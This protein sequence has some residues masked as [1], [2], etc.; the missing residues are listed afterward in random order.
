MDFQ[1]KQGLPF[2]I[3]T[4]AD[5]DI[6][7]LMEMYAR[8]EPRGH[9]Q[10][11]PPIELEPC[12]AWIERLFGNGMN[13]L[14][15]RDGRIIGHAALLPDLNLRDGEYLVF[16]HQAHRGHGIGA[17]LTRR[18]I[19]RAQHLG[20]TEVWLTVDVTNYIAIRL[21]RKCGFHFCGAPDF[22]GE[23]KMSLPLSADK[24]N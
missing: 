4:G 6:A 1:D 7:P 5:E 21:Y 19:E 3:R 20:L 16:L 18:A 8:F 10:G 23:R 11:I 22:E 17:V 2:E 15:L 12:L 13:L 9:Y 24:G 14:A